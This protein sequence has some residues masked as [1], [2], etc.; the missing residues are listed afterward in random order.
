MYNDYQSLPLPP[1]WRRVEIVSIKGDANLV[2]FINDVTR[3][4]TDDHPFLKFISDRSQFEEKGE[5]ND[6]AD[7]SEASKII[8]PQLGL[9]RYSE[10]RCTWKGQYLLEDNGILGLTIRFQHYDEL[11]LV[12]FDGADYNWTPA[13]LECYYG[14]ITQYDL[15]VGSKI[16]LGG[17]DILITSASAEACQRIEG[18]YKKLLKEQEIMCSKVLKC[19]IPPVIRRAYALPGSVG[20]KCVIRGRRNL[21]RI[22]REN[23]CLKEQLIATGISVYSTTR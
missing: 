4:I 9:E 6:G 3:E 2:H 1:P 22:Y 23:A 19:G 13:M 10:F 20:L 17:S 5:L 21:R 15:F 18:L 12:R 16:K 14:P 11:C 7:Q 8:N